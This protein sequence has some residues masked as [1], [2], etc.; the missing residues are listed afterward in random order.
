MRVGLS[1]TLE[2]DVT[3][4]DTASALLS[5]D[6][7]VLGT[8]RLV[9]WMEAATVAATQDSLPAG[10]SSVGTRVVVEHRAASPLGSHI[11]VQATLRHV[12]GRLIKFEV[13]ATDSES[14]IVLGHGEITRVVVDRDRFL[15]RVR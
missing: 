2:F 10:Q 6:L 4:Q 15:A 3:E 12:D 9:A 13:V 8:P 1:G 5:G 11:S 14:G 7:P